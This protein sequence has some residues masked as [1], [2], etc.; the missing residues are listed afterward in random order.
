[1]AVGCMP[2][3]GHRCTDYAVTSLVWWAELRTHCVPVSCRTEKPSNQTKVMVMLDTTN[4]QYKNI[5][6]HYTPAL[7]SGQHSTSS[8]D[9]IHTLVFFYIF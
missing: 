1:M 9:N 4:K 5:K 8:T 2:Q 6:T 3:Q 7:A